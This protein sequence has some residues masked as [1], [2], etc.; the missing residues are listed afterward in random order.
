MI[1]TYRIIHV[2]KFIMDK[3]M[4]SECEY[5]RDEGL[6]INVWLCVIYVDLQDSATSTTVCLFFQMASDICG[7]VL[8]QIP[9]INHAKLFLYFMLL[10]L[11]WS[12]LS[13]LQAHRYDQRCTWS[14]TYL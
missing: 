4:D 12:D 1:Y 9:R 14:W 5:M 6:T 2:V 13:K 11:V 3:I 8:E 10:N 7:C